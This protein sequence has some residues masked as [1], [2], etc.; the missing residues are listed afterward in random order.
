MPELFDITVN[1]EQYEIPTESMEESEPHVIQTESMEETEQ[2]EETTEIPRTEIKKLKKNQ[3]KK[4]HF[5]TRFLL[6][7]YL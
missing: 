3:T 7:Q 1:T 6:N 4:D 2:Y 5:T